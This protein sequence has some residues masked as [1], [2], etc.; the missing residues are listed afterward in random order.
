MLFLDL[1][2]LLDLHEYLLDLVL[3]L[4]RDLLEEIFEEGDGDGNLLGVSLSSSELS[5]GSG[6][7]S[8]EGSGVG[9]L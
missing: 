2:L 6:V 4:F 8:L 5:D 3:E 9:S 1:T 7:G